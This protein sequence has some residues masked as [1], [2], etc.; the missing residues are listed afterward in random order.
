MRIR[1]TTHATVVTVIAMAHR[2][3]T[4]SPTR[5]CAAQPAASVRTGCPQ[6]RQPVNG[7]I[8]VADKM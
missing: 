2:C 4:V 8:S 3:A 1:R 5:T 7:W 6:L